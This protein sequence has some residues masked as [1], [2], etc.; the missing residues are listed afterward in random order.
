MESDR[1]SSGSTSR[2]KSILDV[3]ATLSLIAASGTAMWAITWDR[4]HYRVAA[5]DTKS[6]PAKPGSRPDPPLP[7]SPLSLT[8]AELMG[9][10]T[11]RVA[12]VE[13]S[14]FQCPFCSRFARETLPA[15]ETGY[16]RS[17][18]VLFAFRNFPLASLHPFAEGAA[19]AAV[20][21]GR[22]GHFWEMHD[23][24]FKDQKQLD[25]PSLFRHAQ[26]L[27]L[28]AALFGSCLQGEAAAQ[29]QADSQD[30]QAVGVSGTPAFILGVIQPDGRVRAVKRLSGAQPVRQFQVVLDSLLAQR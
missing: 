17:G 30:G 26:A 5:E 21:A 14:D 19:E 11:A 25:Q 10:K 6:A 23:E 3:T 15:L 24:L 9:S 8:G 27:R 22:Q 1:S 29:V 4:V 20:C 28:D 7:S 16:V 18:K 2:W 12:V 13:Y